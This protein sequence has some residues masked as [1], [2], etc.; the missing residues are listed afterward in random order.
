MMKEGAI[1]RYSHCDLCGKP[2]PKHEVDMGAAEHKACW[3]KWVEKAR[4]PD[5]KDR[6][7][8]LVI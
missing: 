6:H 1:K 4:N 3:E 7:C 8:G 5:E 2:L